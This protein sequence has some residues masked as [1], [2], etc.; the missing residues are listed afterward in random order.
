M[1]VLEGKKK[2]KFAEDGFFGVK[3]E[4]TFLITPNQTF[5]LMHE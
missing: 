1:N 3:E 2:A 4:L 5:T